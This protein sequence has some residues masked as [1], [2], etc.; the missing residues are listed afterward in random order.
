MN[1]KENKWEKVKDMDG[2][3]RKQWGYHRTKEYQEL[4]QVAENLKLGE[5]ICLDISHVEEEADR[6]HLRRKYYAMKP[7]INKLLDMK[8]RVN[9]RDTKIYF[10][11]I[12]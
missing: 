11:R 10:T 8:F 3:N 1:R 9:T 2:L 7:N 12:E 5:I 4:I 6:Y